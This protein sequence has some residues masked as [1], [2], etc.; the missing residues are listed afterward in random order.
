MPISVGEKQLCI[1]QPSIRH[2]LF[3]G[4]KKKKLSF[5]NGTESSLSMDVAVYSQIRKSVPFPST[6]A[7]VWNLGIMY[8][9]CITAVGNAAASWL[10][11]STTQILSVEFGTNTDASIT[12]EFVKVSQTPLLT[13]SS[14]TCLLWWLVCIFMSE[15]QWSR[16]WCF[17]MWTKNN[18][19]CLKNIHSFQG[20][21]PSTDSE[22]LGSDIILVKWD[23]EI[24]MTYMMSDKQKAKSK[25]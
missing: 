5:K 8:N 16:S 15:K 25:L 24:N 11:V 22:C 20:S 1:L 13:C 12:W 17:F 10:A 21:S 18:L 23:N 14:K 9:L 3:W 7:M 6:P 19:R 2:L 4:K